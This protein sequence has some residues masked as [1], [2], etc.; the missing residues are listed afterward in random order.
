MAVV[1]GEDMVKLTLALKVAW[2]DLTKAHA[3]LNQMKASY[4]DDVPRTDFES[5]EKK[6]SNLLQEVSI[7]S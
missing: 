3:T 6:Y 7:S 5:L 1:K 4:G 2:Q